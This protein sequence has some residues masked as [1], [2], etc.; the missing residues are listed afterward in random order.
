VQGVWFRGTTRE[1]ARSLGLSGYVRN[2]PDGRVEAVFEGPEHAVR[3]AVEWCRRGP[4]AARV[5]SVDVT[6]G[7]PTGQY[8]GFSVIY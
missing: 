2:L 7:A 1:V 6:W 5:D 3:E 8:S 4:P